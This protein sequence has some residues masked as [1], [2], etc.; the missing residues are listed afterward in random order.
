MPIATLEALLEV[1]TKEQ[2]EAL[3]PIRRMRLAQT[4][5]YV[6]GLADPRKP[7]DPRSGPL[8]LLHA[9]ERSENCE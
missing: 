4:L 5:T 8:A 3:S 1:V 9:G 6:A 2:L 7:P